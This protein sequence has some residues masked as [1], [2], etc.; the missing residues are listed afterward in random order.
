MSD[1]VGPV[2]R[3]NH[4]RGHRYEDAHGNRVPGVTTI[5]GG[6]VPKPGLIKWS[7]DATIAHAIDNW[8]ELSE[9]PISERIKRLERARF[10][11]RDSAAHRGTQIHKLAQRLVA[12][13]EVDV[14]D[15]LVGQVHAY[16]EFLDQWRVQPRL[17]EYVVMSHRHGYAGTADLNADLIDPDDTAGTQTWLLDVKSSRSGV[18]GET[19]LQ[20]AAY[21]YA[22][23]YIGPDGQEHELP[24]VQRT[25]VVH[26]RPDGYELVP[27]IAGPRQ[28][29]E[30][31]YT[32]QVARFV[33]GARDLVGEALTP[34]RRLE[35]VS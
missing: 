20:L 12:G 32:Q 9:L 18:Y 8:A 19:A 14:P 11:D 1:F 21:R 25:G 35:A 17:V 23:V 29:R 4:G 33:D 30:F 28:H 27:V 26:V 34:P 22:D 6:G 10:A 2:R 15:E 5:L 3:I 24:P 31:L 7:A 16:V 13:H